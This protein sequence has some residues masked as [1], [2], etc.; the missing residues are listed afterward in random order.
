MLCLGPNVYA[1]PSECFI[2]SNCMIIN[3]KVIDQSLRFQVEKLGVRQNPDG[4][5]L[6]DSLIKHP[7]K[8][9]DNGKKIFEYLTS[10]LTQFHLYDW[11]RLSKS[12]F[13]PIRNK[14]TNEVVLVDSHNCFFKIQVEMYLSFHNFLFSFLWFLVTVINAFTKLESLNRNLTR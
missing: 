5:R 11:V 3:F 4:L 10:Q 1:K 14:I 2:N 8:D 6:L 13:I 9:E 12:K 7:P